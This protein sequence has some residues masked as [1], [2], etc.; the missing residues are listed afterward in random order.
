MCIP[1]SVA[2]PSSVS[3]SAVKA[4]DGELIDY[5]ESIYLES[6]PPEERRLWQGVVDGSGP[7]L[8][9]IVM[10]GVPCGMLSCWF[11][12]GFVYIEHLAVDVSKR[13]C[14][15][16]SAVLNVFATELAANLPVVVEV[17]HPESD[18]AVRR[19]AF[20]ER[21]GYRII[22]R[23]YVQPPYQA[24]MP[25]VPLMLMSTEDIDSR[26]VEVTLHREVYGV[27]D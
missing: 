17:E 12:S 4:D 19:V 14:G 16:G 3:L 27:A 10:D 6:F 7:R 11:F 5:L 24:G 13:S 8:F 1:M 23:E 2:Y 18:R 20:Y 25:S 21:N 15:V 26:L 9:A 22:S